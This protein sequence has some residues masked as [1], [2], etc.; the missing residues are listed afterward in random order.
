MTSG[1]RRFRATAQV[2]RISSKRLPGDTD[3]GCDHH[4]TKMTLPKR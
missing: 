1:H 3:R 4:V 2:M